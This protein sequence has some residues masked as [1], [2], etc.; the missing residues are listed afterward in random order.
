MP[1]LSTITTMLKYAS[2]AIHEDTKQTEI[3]QALLDIFGDTELSESSYLDFGL[4]SLGAG[5]RDNPI[6]VDT[7]EY[8]LADP[9]LPETDLTATPLGPFPLYSEQGQCERARW[10][11]APLDLGVQCESRWQKSKTVHS[12]CA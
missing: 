8:F 12:R 9:S 6:E 11:P 3:F 7:I 4:K 10:G 2:Y 5:T 1:Q